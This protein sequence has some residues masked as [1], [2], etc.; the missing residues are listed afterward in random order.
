MSEK[1]VEMGRM[2]AKR[3][4]RQKVLLVALLGM[5]AGTAT[6]ASAQSL[7]T[8]TSDFAPGNF[9]PAGP[10]IT[11]APT[12]AYDFDGST[13]NGLANTSAGTSTGG[14][15][16]INTGTNALGYG[17]I[18]DGS[19]FNDLYVQGFL[20]AWDPGGVSGSSLAAYSGTMYMVYTTPTF[21]GNDV[22]YALG[23]QF[24]YPGD[25]Y[26]GSFYFPSSTAYDGMIDGQAT[27][28]A[29]IPYSVTAETGG[30]GFGMN[31][32][33]N[34]GVYNTGVAGVNNVATSPI[35][36]DDISTTLPVAA[37]PEPATLGALGTGLTMLMLRRRRQA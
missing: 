36:V 13:T 3:G 23:L 31:I 22:Y 12:T 19:G 16:Q 7:W 9:K 29:T 14:A 34:A 32:L 5:C 20:N 17:I 21:A 6:H 18:S 26:Y 33:V 10:A 28:T 25:G 27:Y 24:N 15:L 1:M 2:A 35:Y 37:V 11:V 30:G 4:I 8:T